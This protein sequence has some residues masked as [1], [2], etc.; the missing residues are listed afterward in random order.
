MCG[1]TMENTLLQAK[2]IIIEELEKAGLKVL[3]I[4]LFG[5]RAVAM[6]ALRATGIFLL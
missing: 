1:E 5:S 6:P 3:R 2:A 4:L